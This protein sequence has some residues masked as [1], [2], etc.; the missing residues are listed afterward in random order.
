MSWA[1]DVAGWGIQTPIP[2]QGAQQGQILG[3]VGQS[4]PQLNGTPQDQFRQ[5]Q[6]AQIAQLQGLASGQQQG[7]GELAVQR[8]VANAQAAQQAQAR[9]ARGGNAGMAYRQAANNTAGIGL[10]GAGQSQQAAMSDQMNAQNMLSGQLNNGRQQDIGFAGQNAQLQGQNYGQNL[11]ALTTMNGMSLG[12]QIQNAQ[13]QNQF[14]GGLLNQGGQAASGLVSLFSDERLKTGVRD[15]GAEIDEMLDGIRA[16]SYRYKN[17]GRHGR[18][19][20]AGI[21][22]QDLERSVAGKRIV[23][24]LPEGK[25]LDVN[26]AISAALAASARLNQRLRKLE[27]A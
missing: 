15:A 13:Q 3:M 5:Q 4:A 11:G 10:A 6:L 23:H 25:A 26:K 21:M 27:A 24:E 20:R 22:A 18:G 14:L 16:K 19:E 1:S 9:M 12:A 17:E 7:A 2:T 8:Q